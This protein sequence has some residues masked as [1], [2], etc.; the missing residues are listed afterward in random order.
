MPKISHPRFVVFIVVL[1]GLAASLWRPFGAAHAIS[2]AFDI[3]AVGFVAWIAIM[4][5]RSDIDD[6]RRHADENDGGR[7]AMLLIAAALAL[8]VLVT[9]AS[10]LHPSASNGATMMNTAYPVVTIL[11]AWFF[12]N[13]V[14]TL[15]Y[16]HLYYDQVGAGESA[17]GDAGDRGGLKFPDC[18]TPDYWDFAYFAFNLGMAFQVSDVGCTSRAMRRA[19]LAHCMIAFF[20]NIGVVALTINIVAGATGGK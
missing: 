17:G 10:E 15:H 3:S 1:I 20:F 2:A 6:I 8:V 11:V 4:M 18:D 16:A 12:G 5:T 14:Y 13:T 7:A 9:V 19:V